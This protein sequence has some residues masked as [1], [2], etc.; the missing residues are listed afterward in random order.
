MTNR[1][2]LISAMKSGDTDSCIELTKKHWKKGRL[3]RRLQIP[4]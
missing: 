1:E 2:S 3:Q 4:L